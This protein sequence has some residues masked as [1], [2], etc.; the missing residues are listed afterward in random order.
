MA[1]EALSARQKPEGVRSLLVE[2][3]LPSRFSHLRVRVLPVDV[4]WY[5]FYQELAEVQR[6][7]GVYVE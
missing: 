6:Y 5:P 1:A 4:V 7:V 2:V 3:G